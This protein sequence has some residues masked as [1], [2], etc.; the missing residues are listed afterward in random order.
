MNSDIKRQYKRIEIANRIE[1]Y[2][3]F[4]QNC[5]NEKIFKEIE[6]RL[7]VLEELQRKNVVKISDT[8]SR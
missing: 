4:L 1:Q 6:A 5:S 2:R 8:T 7:E 3:S